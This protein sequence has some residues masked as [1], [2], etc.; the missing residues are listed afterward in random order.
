MC[1]CARPAANIPRRGSRR[2]AGTSG[3]AAGCE[4]VFSTGLHVLAWIEQPVQMHDEVAHMGVV[5]GL[6]C[7]RPPRRMGRGVIREQADDFH[8]IEI[9][10]CRM[11][12]I[13]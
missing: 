8:L 5:Y 1:W 3:R 11:F 10:E 4:V 7:L 6:L 9:L 12:E 13:C 2:P